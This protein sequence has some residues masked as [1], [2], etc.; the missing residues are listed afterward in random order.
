MRSRHMNPLGDR[1]DPAQNDAKVEARNLA[2]A[3]ELLTRT[4]VV[5]ALHDKNQK[6]KQFKLSNLF[7]T[8]TK[9]QSELEDT[10]DSIAIVSRLSLPLVCL[11]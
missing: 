1:L 7:P 5:V 3:K 8:Q 11:G 9:P 10:I 2:K 6:L 4:L